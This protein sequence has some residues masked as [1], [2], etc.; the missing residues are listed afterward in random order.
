MRYECPYC[1]SMRKPKIVN[2]FPPVMVQ[3]IDCKKEGIEKKFI[4]ED[5]IY[6]K[7][8][9]PIQWVFINNYINILLEKGKFF[10]IF[11]KKQKG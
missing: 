9:P 8:I 10:I 3:C 6:F 1:G 11:K 2:Y 5:E 7:L 4:K